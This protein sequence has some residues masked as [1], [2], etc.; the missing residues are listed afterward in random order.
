MSTELEPIQGNDTFR[1]IGITQFAGGKGVGRC[2]QLTQ[3]PRPD[4]LS[5]HERDRWIPHH[6]VQLTREQAQ[7]LEEELR[8]WLHSVK[9]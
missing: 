6:F 3:A 8:L 5:E 1:E 4:M 7:Q 2:L 9:M